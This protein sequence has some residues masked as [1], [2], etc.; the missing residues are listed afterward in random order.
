MA[1]FTTPGG[2]YW[3]IFDDMSK[4]VHLLIAGSTGS[5]KSVVINGIIST[6][7]RLHSPVSAGFI[8]IDPK[9]VELVQYRAL[10]HTV[11]YASEP[12]T[13]ETVLKRAMQIVDD[14]YRSM[15]S[16]GL[17]KWDGGDLYVVIDELADL[18]TTCRKQCEPLIQRIGQIGRAARCHLIVATQTPIATILSTPIK[19]NL[20]SR[21][22]LRTRSAQDSRNIMGVKCLE[23]LPDH[24]EAYYMKSTGMERRRIPM[25]EDSEIDELVRYWTSRRCISA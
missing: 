16:R 19:C 22:G 18:M 3:P 9:R 5:G 1:C 7:I 25:V 8:L 23:T 6:I 20:D 17:R 13:F 24:G 10:P 12:D 14:R 2:T 21:V 11:A 4:Q 15:Q